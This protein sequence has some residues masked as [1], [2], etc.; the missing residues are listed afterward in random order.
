MVQT[1]LSIHNEN[2]FKVLTFSAETEQ[3]AFTKSVALKRKHHG[4]SRSYAF[5]TSGIIQKR[6]FI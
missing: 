6:R 3:E 1:T 4:D 2:G 5:F